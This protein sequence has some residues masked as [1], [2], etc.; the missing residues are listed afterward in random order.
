MEMNT[1]KF[2]LTALV[3]ISLLATGSLATSV[4]NFTLLDQNGDA[5]ELYYYSDASAIVITVQ[6]NSC[7]I[8]RN[9]LPD[10]KDVRQEYAEKGVEFLMINS[11]LQDN[12]STVSVEAQEWEIDFPIL[13]DEA[14]LVGDSLELT[15][16]AEVLVIDPT[17]WEL[18][19]RGAL[20]DRLSYERQLTEAS[21][22]YVKDALDVVLS[23]EETPIENQSVKGCLINFPHRENGNGSKL[24]Y[25]DDVAPILMDRCTG[26][27][28]EGGIGPWPMNSFEMVRGF[29]PMI[30]E[31]LMTKRMPPWHADPH[32]G[33]WSNDRGLSLE[34]RQTLVRW[35]ENG[36][37][38]GEGPDPLTTV[39]ALVE[40]H[41]WK[42]GAPDLIVKVP[43]F[44]VPASGVVEY[45]YHNIAAEIS[46]PVWIKGFEVRPGN[47]NVVH[48]L[49]MGTVSS[50]RPN[51]NGIFENYIG[52]Y[53]PGAGYA[54]LPEGTG[55]LLNPGHLF[56][57]QMHYTPYGKEVVDETVVGIYLHDEQPPK[58]LRHGVVLNTMIEIPP[59]TKAHEEAAYFLFEDDAI[60]YQIL[61]HSHYRGKASTFSLIYPDGTEELLLSVPNY[62]FNWQTGYVFDS[63]R[64]VPKGAKLVHTTVYDNSTQNPGN[65]DPNRTV[66][67]GL[68]SWDEMLYGDFVFSW[69][70]ET[71]DNPIHNS[72]R[73]RS[74]Q[75]VGMM[76]KNMNGGLEQD[77]LSTRQGRGGRLLARFEDG[78]ADKNGSLDASEVIQLTRML[79]IEAAQRRAGV[80]KREEGE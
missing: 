78:D 12:R 64:D 22:H 8:V 44:T 49:L 13:L 4:E 69:K 18:V 66:R 15:R 2:K 29:A 70:N 17:D 9:L 5:H 45:Q 32:V 52:G 65:P 61:P 16:T 25:V 1:Y 76:D 75:M 30:R 39:D 11:N 80:K 50:D 14:Q 41:D 24:T 19:Y 77:E 74:L 26:C 42:R 23:D 36:T 21:Q 56:Q 47:T 33:N 53:A 37:S 60:L 73:I 7:P 31:V 27:H 57:V 46:E 3:C 59:N 35:V 58:F 10:L 34:E 48:H 67:W 28:V 79:T 43:A 6:G 62:D 72:G 54:V 71:T 55:I 68:Q 51:S 63:P 40:D 38:R 20:N